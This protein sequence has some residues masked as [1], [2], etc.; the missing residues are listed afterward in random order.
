LK[1]GWATIWAIAS[2]FSR[3][4]FPVRL[5]AFIGLLTVVWAPLALVFLLLIPET[6]DR[7][8]GLLL[9]LLVACLGVLVVWN[10]GL[11]QEPIGLSTYGL[12]AH[13]RTL[14]LILLGWGVGSIS[15]LALFGIEGLLGWLGWEPL[16]PASLLRVAVEGA[17]VAIAVGLGEELLFR[18]WLLNELERDYSLVTS[19]WTSSLAFAVLHFIKPFEEIVRTFPQFPGLVL[20][21]LILVWAK[22]SRQN[23]LGLSIGL[24]SGLVWT[25]YL[26]QVGPL[27]KL[28]DHAPQFWVGIDQNP[29]AGMLG[30]ISLAGIAVWVRSFQSL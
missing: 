27:V 12:R 20:L 2:W 23:Q 24:H 19:L 7:D 4:P 21:G 14:K 22:R 18:G 13:L 30:L 25:Y 26:A 11:Y 29:L 9:G 8:L 15:L 6:S 3:R 1:Q 17:G 10:Y 5:V 28:Y 16:P